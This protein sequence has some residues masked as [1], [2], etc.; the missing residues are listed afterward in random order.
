MD[1]PSS[2][3]FDSSHPSLLPHVVWGMVRFSSHVGGW[4]CFIVVIISH[5]TVLRGTSCYLIDIRTHPGGPKNDTM[6][7]DAVHVG[8]PSEPTTKMNA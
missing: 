5:V 7:M 1:S 6:R 2:P 4:S 3:S 8:F